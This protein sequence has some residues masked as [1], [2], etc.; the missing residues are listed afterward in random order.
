MNK[1][2]NS[3][4]ILRNDDIAEWVKNDPVLDKGEIAVVTVQQT[5]TEA[6][7]IMTKVGD[8]IHKYSELDFTYARAADVGTLSIE[9]LEEILI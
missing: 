1:E 3:R 5:D 7:S 2:I 4:I 8:G 6:P 9:D